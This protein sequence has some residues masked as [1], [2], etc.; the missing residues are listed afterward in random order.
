MMKGKRVQVTG[1]RMYD[2]KKFVDSSVR[3]LPDIGAIAVKGD[4]SV[5]IMIWNYHDED[6]TGPAEEVTLNLTGLP[7]K[8]L[9]VTE[10]RVDSANSN[11]YEVWKSMGSPQNP[12]DKQMKVLEKSGQ[13]QNYLHGKRVQ[14]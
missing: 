12:D 11:S 3:G 14:G 2:L 9:T 6:K 13:L 4:H 10:S 1:N 5:T 7:K 8:M